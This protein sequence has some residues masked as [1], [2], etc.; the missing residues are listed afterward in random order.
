MCSES[1]RLQGYSKL[2]MTIKKLCSYWLMG[3]FNGLDPTACSVHGMGWHQTHSACYYLSYL[4]TKT[5]T[6]WI[7]WYKHYKPAFVPAHPIGRHH[8]VPLF[9]ASFVTAIYGWNSTTDRALCLG[10][11]PWRPG[12]S[13]IH[14]PVLAL[15]HWCPQGRW[16]ALFEATQWRIGLPHFIKNEG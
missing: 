2:L 16:N 1:F 3:D 10:F 8:C 7:S 9:S 14:E 13:V 5:S 12:W 11:Q 4:K 6:W 15:T